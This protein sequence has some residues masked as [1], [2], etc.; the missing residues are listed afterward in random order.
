V[1]RLS[2]VAPPTQIRPL[3]KRTREEL[4]RDVRIVEDQIVQAAAHAEA[5]RAVEARA[6]TLAAAALARLENTREIRE[7]IDRMTK[8]AAQLE[9]NASK[10]AIDNEA[11]AERLARK[12]E[13]IVQQPSSGAELVFNAPKDFNTQPWIAEVSDDGLAIVKLGTNRRQLL[14]VDLGPG[15][16]I[17]TWISALTPAGD[18]VLILVRPSGV[19]NV[20]DIRASLDEAGI[21]FGIDFI[22][23]DQVVRDGLGES[24]END[25]GDDAH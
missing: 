8:E 6:R 4:D 10:L 19:D 1:G 22:G 2:L 14:G 15:S 24:Q 9:Q 3:I 23:E 11:E 12:Q 20:F 7:G 18:H 21:P 25:A 13:E 17:A 16:A 5:A